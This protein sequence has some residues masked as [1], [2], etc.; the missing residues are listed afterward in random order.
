[1]YGLIASATDQPIGPRFVRQ[2]DIVTGKIDWTTVPF[3]AASGVELQ[4]YALTEGDLLISRLGAGVGTAARVQEPRGAVFAGYLVRF[5][6]DRGVLD[7]R[8]AGYMLHSNSWLQ[9]VDRVT[10]FP[11]TTLFRSR[12][13]VV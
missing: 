7:D 6:V 8:F 11:Y 1:M 5:Q 12:K 10:L 4:K 3:C 2:T 9:H 13:S